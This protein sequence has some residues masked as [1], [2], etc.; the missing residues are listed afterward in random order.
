MKLTL[1]L[2][3]AWLWTLPTGQP[4]PVDPNRLFLPDDLE[5]TLWAEGPMFYNPTNMDLDARGRVWITEAVDYRDFNNKPDTHLTHPNGERVMILEDTDHDGKAD[6]STVFVEDKELV[7]P[8]GIAVL[9]NKVYVSC[10]PSLVVY[11]DENGDDKADKKEIFLT[12][13]GGLDHDHSLHA[14]VAGPDGNYYFNTGNAGPHHVTD[15]AGWT[16]RSGSLYV[17][18]TPYNKLNKGN[19]VS[20][21]GR[22]WVGGL[23]L[24]IRPDGTGLKVMAHN[25][26]NNY[27][28]GI[29]S[30]GNLF[31]NDN[32]DQVVAC[33]TSFLMEGA[34][35]GYFSSDGTRYWQGDQRPGQ[36]IPTAH[37]HQ[38]DPGVMP[39]GDISGAGS[40]TGVVVYEGDELG[41][42]YRGTLLSAEAGRNVIFGYK[43]N[44]QGA[45]YDLSNRR[46][47]ISTFPKVDENYKWN[48][49]GDDPRKWFRPSDVSVGPDGAIYIADWYDPIVGGHAMHDKKGYGRIF[50]ITPKGKN[51]TVPTLNLTTTKGQIA[52]LQSPAI[53]VRLL[54]FNALR[55]Q[56]D[57]VAKPVSE[58]LNAPNPYHRARAV[59]LLSQLGPK[60]HELA[61]NALTNADPQLRLTA[62]RAL[63]E[64]PATTLVSLC[65]Q[66]VNDPSPAMR[67]EVAIAL[68][69]VPAPQAVPLLLTLMNGYDGSDRYY[70]TALGIGAQGKESPIG[71]AITAQLSPDPASWNPKLADLLWE[72]H[73]A[74]ATELFTKWASNQAL[75]AD[76]RQQAL[77]GLGFVRTPMAARAMVELAKSRD[78][79]LAKQAAYWVAFRRG[80]DWATL[81]NWDELLPNKLSDAEQQVLAQRQQ[82]L[83]EYVS[84][85]DKTKLAVS[86]AHTPE[87][88]RL[89]V[90]LVADRKLPK[91]LVGP[92]SEV[93]FTNPDQSVRT[94]AS[95]YFNKPGTARTVS[96]RQIASLT[97]NAEV[98]KAV[99]T[100]NCATCHK[101]GAAGAEIGPELTKIHEKFDRNGLLDAIVN[102]SAA[103]AF[104]YE[105]WLITTRNGQTYY[106]FL[107]SD[108][109]Q[110]IVVKDAAGQKHT[111]P[112]AQ[113]AS[114][115][116]YTTS[117]MPDPVAMGLTD[118][119]LADLSAFLLKR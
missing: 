61:T 34:N 39:V 15:K 82:L 2:F 54:G 16:L 83:D 24:R 50:R 86:M 70:L 65:R 20:D 110:A 84:I 44:P 3:A 67:R 60:G 111:L 25:F 59:W 95:D 80:N 29:D 90:G 8:L 89:L 35:A 5:A 43:L 117:L 22:V 47:L 114:R 28:T 38:Q 101:H 119:Q 6:K 107:I 88:G 31:Q 102:P 7:S 118:Q 14:L 68:R 87:G 23:A 72:L 9:G 62:F 18:G 41:E 26:R 19:Q 96:I 69:D 99:F 12:G 52:A 36:P 116:Q 91:E 108:G 11:T 63:K 79:T 42:A 81:V 46:D 13:F 113:V 32:D 49:V 33:R 74:E 37:W 48:D 27:E 56:G 97:G 94:M 78:T 93:I 100:T 103:L 104:G 58:L 105:P 45:G 98:G 112:T 71:Q 30:Y 10:A 57:K 21:D 17:G 51:L 109:A 92:V 77:T 55:M 106:G 64:Q 76:A 75:T 1:P 66:L 73:P 115:K 4:E 53:N 85:A 40:P